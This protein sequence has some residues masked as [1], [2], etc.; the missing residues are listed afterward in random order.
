MTE[1]HTRAFIAD[2]VNRGATPNRLVEQSLHHGPVIG[3]LDPILLGEIH[4]LCEDDKDL[5]AAQ[6]L[7]MQISFRLHALVAK[8]VPKL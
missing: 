8:R 3:M 5:I 1:Q 7:A 2:M 6:Q 4:E